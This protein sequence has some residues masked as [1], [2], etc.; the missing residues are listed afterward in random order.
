MSKFRIRGLLR[1]KLNSV[2]QRRCLPRNRR[3]SETPLQTPG[4]S[5]EAS[6]SASI[7]QRV[8]V[9]GYVVPRVGIGPA[10]VVTLDQD[11]LDKQGDQTVADAVLTAARERW[12]FHSWE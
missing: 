12:Q 6:P 5:E 3:R 9:T 11:F 8:V 2:R 1:L 7:L 10:P 4:T